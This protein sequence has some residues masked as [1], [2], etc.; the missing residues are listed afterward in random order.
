MSVAGA[1]L[2]GRAQTSLTGLVTGLACHYRHSRPLNAT[3]LNA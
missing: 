3:T 2:T 1:C